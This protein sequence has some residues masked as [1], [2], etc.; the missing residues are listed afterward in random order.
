MA[1]PTVLILG[2]Y[3]NYGFAVAEALLRRTEANLIVAGRNAEKARTVAAQLNAAFAGEDFG[4][5]RATSLAVDVADQTALDEAFSRA[6]WVVVAAN[7]AHYTHRLV[8]GL[9][10]NGVDCIDAQYSPRKLHEWR[11][12]AAEIRAAGRCV[13]S[14]AGLLPG[15]PAALVRFAAERIPRLHEVRMAFLLK[16]DWSALSLSLDSWRELTAALAAFEHDIFF[17]GAWHP[18]GGSREWDFGTELGRTRA[19]P[20]CLPELYGLPAELP[21]LREV[22][23]YVNGCNE[24]VD[25]VFSIVMRLGRYLFPRH[26][27]EWGAGWLRTALERW[28]GPPYAA[29]LKLEAIGTR[30]RDRIRLELALSHPDPYRLSAGMVAICLAQHLNQGLRRPGVWLQGQILDSRDLLQNL[31][32]V[33]STLNLKENGRQFTPESV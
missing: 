28:S 10:R 29:A 14:E 8:M 6:D 4:V 32:M 24:W 2:G 25:S 31:K 15:L 22:A 17:E 12:H 16:P 9:L 23:L 5:Y 27:I 21:E 33:G 18:Y 20:V 11:Q 7:A 1:A 19:Y 3:G 26:R 13:I 30:G